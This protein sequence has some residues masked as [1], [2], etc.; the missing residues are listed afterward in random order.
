MKGIII[1]TKKVE[2]KTKQ[3]KLIKYFLSFPSLITSWITK[4][5]YITARKLKT[6]KEITK[7]T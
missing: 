1:F 2:T 4:F 7:F 3:N 5:T 6:K